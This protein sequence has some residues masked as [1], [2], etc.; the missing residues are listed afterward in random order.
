MKRLTLV[1]ALD[2]PEHVRVKVV[3]LDME[4]LVTGLELTGPMSLVF[5]LSSVMV[6]SVIGHEPFQVK[7]VV[8]L[9]KITTFGF[10]SIEQDAASAA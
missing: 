5:E 3:V 9:G 2:P 6:Q 10:A 4:G 7:L 1:V 8:L